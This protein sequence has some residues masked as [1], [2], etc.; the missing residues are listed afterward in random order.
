MASLP[1]LSRDVALSPA[2]QERPDLEMPPPTAVGLPERAVQFGT[3]AFLRGFVDYFVDAANRQGS[4]AGSIVAVGSTES[5]RDTVLNEQDGLYTLAVRGLENGVPVERLR[6]V[7]SLSRAL[8]AVSEWPA[9]LAVA[10][11]PNIALV[12]SNTTEVGIALDDTDR[13][14]LDPPRSFPGKL[15]RFLYERATAFDYDPAAGVVVLPCE[16]LENNGA[17]L[18]EIVRTLAG[19]WQLG[20]RFERWLDRHIVFCNT[21]VD[22]IVAGTP[23]SDEVKRFCDTLG[24]ADSLLTACETYRLFAIEGDAAIR[25]RLGFADADAGIVVAPDISDY[26]ELK[27]RVLNGAHTAMVPVALLCGLETVRDAVED[28]HVG[29]FVRTIMFDEVV[30]SLSAGGGEEFAEAVLQRFGNPF[31][32]HAL[33]DITLHGTTKLRVRVVPSIIEL[34]HRAGRIADGLAFA[35]AAHLLFLRGD[36]QTERRERGLAVPDDAAGAVVQA[37][38]R[39]VDADS[40]YALGAFVEE[41]CADESL[42]GVDL[43]RLPGFVAAVRDHLARCCRRG[44][45]AALVCVH[46]DREGRHPERSEGSAFESRSSQ[47]RDPEADPS[48]A[49]LAQDDDRGA[50]R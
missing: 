46:G 34:H 3:G 32:R 42:W 21:L 14:D 10:R 25:A 30:P 1:R 40:D 28:A 33:I 17:Q 50:S 47:L 27:V 6:V 49:A 4:F 19:R 23:A 44:V 7:A 31:I 9:V 26:R 45:R 2:W 11:D 37:Y 41:V 18:G 15:T 39:G 36:L 48:L 16:L 5:G 20:L 8:S 35:F 29:A 22:R 38:W 12:F 24:Y 43:S 13:A